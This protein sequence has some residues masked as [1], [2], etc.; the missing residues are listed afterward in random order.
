MFQVA[1]ENLPSVHCASFGGSWRRWRHRGLW[2][3][4]FL[5]SLGRE[6]VLQ[7]EERDHPEE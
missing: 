7:D 2:S 5:F 3:S 4:C 1:A 6:L